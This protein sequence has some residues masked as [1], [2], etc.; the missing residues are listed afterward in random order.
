VIHLVVDIVLSDLKYL[1]ID[2]LT[3]CVIRKTRI[4]IAL[5]C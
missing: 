2:T 1:I 3:T 5:A 4:W